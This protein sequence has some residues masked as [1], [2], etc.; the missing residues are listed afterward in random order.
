[1]YLSKKLDPPALRI[2]QNFPQPGFRRSVFDSIKTMK[3]FILS[4]LILVLALVPVA[5]AW[6]AETTPPEV[7]RRSDGS[8]VTK[9]PDGRLEVDY[10][11]LGQTVT[12]YPSPD[13]SYY[14]APGSSTSTRYYIDGRT[15]TRYPDGKT[16]TETRDGVSRTD[17]PDGRIETRYTDGSIQT[18]YPDGRT[19]MQYPE[20]KTVTRYPDDKVEIQHPDGRIETKLPSK[21]L[22][23]GGGAHHDHLNLDTPYTGNSLWNTGDAAVEAFVTR[24]DGSQWT[25][26]LDPGQTIN[27]DEA[28]LGSA[29]AVSLHP[30]GEG[31]VSAKIKNSNDTTIGDINTAGI[32]STRILKR[33]I[34]QANPGRRRALEVVRKRKAGRKANLSRCNKILESSGRIRHSILQPAGRLLPAA[35]KGMIRRWL[36]WMPREGWWS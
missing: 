24:P 11:P 22:L 4:V 36:S 14:P 10:P 2:E 31:N 29:T 23:I 28:A 9:Y 7:T 30:L 18:E 33:R 34:L 32:V 27:I 8:I 5:S 15:V 26:V 17:H 21:T 6:S 19:V 3:R 20:G 16:K 25:I 35:R 1:M 13:G 12:H